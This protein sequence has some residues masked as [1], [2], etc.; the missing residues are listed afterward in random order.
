MVNMNSNKNDIGFSLLGIKTEQFA[1][2][3]EKYN[4]SD[5]VGLEAE[6][7]FKLDRKNYRIAVFSYFNFIQNDNIII[8]LVLSC[9][10]KIS[11]DAWNKFLNK[12]KA[13]IL[14]PKNFATHLTVLTVG[15][16][17]GV[18][19]AK[20]EGTDLCKHMIPTLDLTN[21]FQEDLVFELNDVKNIEPK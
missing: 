19:H 8:K 3:D 5:K 9:H 20:L 17:R 6:F 7:K 13:E 12:E 1:V 16:A 10:F 2:M 11:S 21:L 18:M 4:P 14:V 15:T